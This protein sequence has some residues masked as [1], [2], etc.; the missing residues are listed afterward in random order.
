M[1]TEEWGLNSRD[2][3]RA[4]AAL[5]PGEQ[6]VLVVKPLVTL[7]PLTRYLL[8]GMGLLLALWLLN[9]WESVEEGW[10]LVAVVPLLLCAPW[11]YRRYRERTL[12]LLT[13]RRV[14]MLEPGLLFM[15]RT[16]SY[17]LHSGLV[18]EVVPGADG[19]GDIV[20]AYEP[21]WRYSHNQFR[22]EVVPVGFMGVPQVERVVQMITQQVAAVVPTDVAPLPATPGLPTLPVPPPVAPMPGPV[23]VPT[24]SW[25][26]ARPQEPGRGAL[27]GFGLVFTLFSLTFAV[28]GGYKMYTENRLEAEGCH[29]V[30]TVV[31]VNAKRRT[32]NHHRSHHHGT[33]ITI[34][35]GDSRKDRSSYAYYPVFQFTDAQGTLHEYESTIGGT[36]YNYPR[37]HKVPVVYDP[38]EPSQVR[39]EGEGASTGLV[40]TL[41]GSLLSIV[42]IGIF[43]GGLKK[44]K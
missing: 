28:F 6:V 25:G 33:G 39:P 15:S 22:R 14:V 18:K 40:F 21:R 26:N 11:L 36:E 19:S 35:I 44:K 24:D 13:N 12:Y 29:V 5:Q 1:N 42:G 37:G 32:T 23:A 16:S 2:A 7:P 20:F 10:L 34:R 27:I 8:M 4:A 41:A 30:A 31:K 9:D 17:P 38:A 3:A 43:I